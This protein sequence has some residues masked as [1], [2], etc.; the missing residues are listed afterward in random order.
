MKRAIVCIIFVFALHTAFT[1]HAKAQYRSFVSGVELFENLQYSPDTWQ[2]RYAAGYIFG[3]VDTANGTWVTLPPKMDRHGLLTTVTQYLSAHP[4][5]RPAPAAT[6]IIKAMR[7]VAPA[8]Q[9]K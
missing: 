2:Y 8:P 7:T 6:L 3:V 4:K 5:E 9:K 1:S